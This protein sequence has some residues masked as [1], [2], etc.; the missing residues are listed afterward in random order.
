MQGHSW[1]GNVRELKTAVTHALALADG[2]PVER[3]HFPEPL[4]GH[5]TDEAPR[6]QDAILH[7]ACARSRAR[8]RRRQR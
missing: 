2:A 1:P 6:S 5:A 8:R 4:L 3:H 7:D